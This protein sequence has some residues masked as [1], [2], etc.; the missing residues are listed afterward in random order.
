MFFKYLVVTEKKSKIKLLKARPGS[1]RR[2]TYFQNN[3]GLGCFLVFYLGH[4]SNLSLNI[5][6][7]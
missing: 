5:F 7:M 6:E 1:R 2:M 3:N 4:C